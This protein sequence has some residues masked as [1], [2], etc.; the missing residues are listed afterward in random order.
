MVGVSLRLVCG[1]LCCRGWVPVSSAS[2][3]VLFC[4]VLAHCRFL[5]TSLRSTGSDKHNQEEER[6]RSVQ[7]G[8][9]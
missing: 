3:T 2:R 9:P 7:S 5:R 1:C 4:Y 6:P 8:A